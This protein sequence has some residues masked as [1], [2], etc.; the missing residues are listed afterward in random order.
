MGN[1]LK[2]SKGIDNMARQTAVRPPQLPAEVWQ[3][4]SNN[5]SMREW[6]FLSSTC[7][8]MHSMQPVWMDLEIATPLAFGW[9]QKRWGHAI[10]LDLVFSTIGLPWVHEPCSLP[11]LLDLRLTFNEKFD[12]PSAGFLTWLLAR[13]STL[14]LLNIISI[15]SLVLPPLSNLRHLLISSN[16]IS[17]STAASL[18]NLHELVNLCLMRNDS[19]CNCPR[20]SLGHL[21]KLA[22]VLIQDVFVAG[23]EFPSGCILHVTS[24]R[25]RDTRV[26]WSDLPSSTRLGSLLVLDDPTAHENIPDFVTTAKFPILQWNFDRLGSPQNLVSVPRASFSSLTA[27]YLNGEAIYIQLPR[28]LLLRI[29]QVSAGALGLECE[30][31]KALAESLEDLGIIYETVT[32]NG[33]ITLTTALCQAGKWLVPVDASNLKPGEAGVFLK[34]FVSRNDPWPCNCGACPHCLAKIGVGQRFL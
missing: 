18:G 30:D 8:A 4:V 27:L 24:Q 26:W 1:Q 25:S 10:S 34:S 16:D 2:C 22:T 20:L 23:L 32:G 19:E 14:R 12:S 11:N 15:D 6:V 29:L 17:E 28:T 21:S 5:L 33:M 9:M 3:R 31:P 7:K 13:A